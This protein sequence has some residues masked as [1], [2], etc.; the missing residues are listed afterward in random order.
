VGFS[1]LGAGKRLDRHRFLGFGAMALG[2]LFKNPPQKNFEISD[3]INACWGT[4]NPGLQ[5]I[6]YYGVSFHCAILL[7]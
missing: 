2:I 3:F 5:K 1:P 7:P 6:S 4:A